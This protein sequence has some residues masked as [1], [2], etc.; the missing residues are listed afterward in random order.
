MYWAG[1]C[2][3]LIAAGANAVANLSLKRLV[4]LGQG[5]DAGLS[6]YLN[7][8]GLAWFGILALSGA[9]LLFF[10]A[11][12]LKNLPLHI[13]YALCTSVAL[14]ILSGINAF[15][16]ESPMSL[17]NILGIVLISTGIFLINR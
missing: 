2:F 14:V 15:T 10:Y 6:A 3:A 1:L 8:T 13:A 9:L 12:A 7:A 16:A 5:S 17:L 4:R 11:L